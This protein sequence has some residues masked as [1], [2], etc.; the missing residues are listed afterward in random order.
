MRGVAASESY[1]DRF[2]RLYGLEFGR[3]RMGIARL[4]DGRLRFRAAVQL[5]RRWLTFC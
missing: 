1:A 3:I 2:S 4:G 5:L